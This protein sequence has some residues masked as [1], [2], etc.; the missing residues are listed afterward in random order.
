[1]TTNNTAQAIDAAATSIE[2]H[3]EQAQVER[4]NNTEVTLSNGIILS[5]NPVPPLMIRHAGAHLPKPK[6]PIVHIESKGREEENPSDPYFLEQL[7][8]W[9][10]MV[11]ETAVNVLIGVGTSVV[12]V[13]SGMYLPEDEGWAEM[14]E[15][16]GIVV[17]TKNAPARYLS[18]LRFYALADTK[19]VELAMGRVAMVAGVNE[20]DVAEAMSSFPGGEKGRP[21]SGSGAEGDGGHGD[22]VPAADSGLGTGD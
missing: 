18:W 20:K 21:D 22:P 10:N 3:E 14:A 5:I 19:D 7:Q 15:A 16:V 11:N 12:S 6:P 13:P 9:K 2:E 4:A 8:D 17:N 1:M